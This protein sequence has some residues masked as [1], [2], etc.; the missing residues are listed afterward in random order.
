MTRDEMLVELK[1]F[2][3]EE[4]LDGRGAGFD[5]HTPLLAWGVIDSLS[6]AQLVS[7]AEE[8]LGID[9]PQ[10]EVTPDHL[11]NLAAFVD[12]LARLAPAAASRPGA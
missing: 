3:V 11:E 2:V 6:A 12:M 4:L 7:F 9:V 5:E 10:R 8:R 1:G